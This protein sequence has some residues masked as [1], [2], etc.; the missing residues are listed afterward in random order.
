MASHLVN[1]FRKL[2]L[3]SC[4][5]LGF[6]LAGSALR[7]EDTAQ[8]TPAGEAPATPQPVEVYLGRTVAQ[9]MHWSG[10]GWLIRH[11]REREEASELMRKQLDLK[12]GMMVCD[13]GCGNG[14]HTLPMA[15]A[16]APAG[17]VYGVEI[18]KEMLKMLSDRAEAQHVS[19]IV[20]VVGEPYDPKLPVGTLDIILCVDVY[21]EFSYPEQM[22]AGMRKA[23]KPDGKVV[24]VEYRAEDDEVPIKPEH[25][26]T[27]DQV[28]KELTANGFKLVKQFDGLPWQHM[29]WFG[30]DEGWRK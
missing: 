14:Y 5:G 2:R 30:R 9:T 17:K 15:Q 1:S 21:H 16:V 19:N 28:T 12:P 25:K 26:M 24:M 13:M 8:A 10:A 22:L 11:K 7:A 18:Q 4:T 3:V 20:Q 29:M 27:K 6:L 23:L